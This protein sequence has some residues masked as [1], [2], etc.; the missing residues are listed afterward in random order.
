MK[1]KKLSAA[2]FTRAIKKVRVGRGYFTC[3]IL[4]DNSDFHGDEELA[5]YKAALSSYDHMPLIR[6]AFSHDSMIPEDEELYTNRI[7]ALS[8][9]RELARDGYT[10]K[11]FFPN[12]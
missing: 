12:S 5:L 2:V 11:D 6:A 4:W 8:L 1:Q 7:I 10:A 9:A 3:N